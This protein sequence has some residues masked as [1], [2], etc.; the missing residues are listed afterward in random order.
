[1]SDGKK[2]EKELHA[3]FFRLYISNTIFLSQKNE[4]EYKMDDMLKQQIEGKHKSVII[5]HPSPG[6]RLNMLYFLYKRLSDEQYTHSFYDVSGVC[7]KTKT[8]KGEKVFLNVCTTTKIPEPKEISEEKLMSLL[9]EES[10]DYSIPMSIG[11]ERFEPDKGKENDLNYPLSL[12]S[13]VISS[14]MKKK[15]KESFILQVVNYARLTT[16]R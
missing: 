16:S 11:D 7:V 13:R 4:H 5:I 2:K 9:D 8:D 12:R 10:S 15:K 14:S 6:M 3:P 1:M